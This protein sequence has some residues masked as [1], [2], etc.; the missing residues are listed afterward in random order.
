MFQKQPDII[1]CK[2]KSPLITAQLSMAMYLLPL[3]YW[4]S[5]SIST[6]SPYISKVRVAEVQTF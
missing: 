3:R 6:S 5:I 2:S 4:T 1:I